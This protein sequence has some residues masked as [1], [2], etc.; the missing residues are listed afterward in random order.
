MWDTN[1]ALCGLRDHRIC[2]Q[3]EHRCLCH[4]PAWAAATCQGTQQSNNPVCLQR[5]FPEKSISGLIPAP[6]SK[7]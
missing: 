5:C 2:S 4:S 3:E 1:P 7:C 6:L